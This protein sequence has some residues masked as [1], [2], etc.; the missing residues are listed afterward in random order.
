[1][2]SI[3]CSD[4]RRSGG[5]DFVA[6]VASVKVYRAEVARYGPCC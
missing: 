4:G 1:M 3:D 6:T 2:A 5:C